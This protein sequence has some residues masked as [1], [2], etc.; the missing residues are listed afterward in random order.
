[1]GEQLDKG[2]GFQTWP[3]RAGVWCVWVVF[4][5]K[6]TQVHKRYLYHD[7]LPGEQQ[8]PIQGRT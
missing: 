4:T 1:M 5:L 8:A 2:A 3:Q 7:R 6:C